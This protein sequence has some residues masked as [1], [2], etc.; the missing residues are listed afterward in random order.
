MAS[1]IDSVFFSPAFCFC[2]IFVSYWRRKQ[3]TDHILSWKLKTCV[4]TSESRVKTVR[5][6][7]GRPTLVHM[8]DWW[9]ISQ[10]VLSVLCKNSAY[11]SVF[12][13]WKGLRKW[14]KST[15]IMKEQN[16]WLKGKVDRINENTLRSWN[17]SEEKENLVT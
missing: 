2:W 1:V 14:G 16:K 8:S 3:K 4:K 17:C 6:S 9:E 12:H 5:T 11:N 15:T 7:L 13:V 10:T